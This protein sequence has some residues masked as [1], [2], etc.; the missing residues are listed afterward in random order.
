VALRAV[1]SLLVVPLVVVPLAA[2]LLAGCGF[3]GASNVSHT[4][5][6][7]FVLRGRVTVPVAGSGPVAD[8]TA[9]TSALP[10]VAAGTTVLVSDPDGHALAH[11]ELGGGVTTTAT[12]GSSAAGCDFPFQV[13]GVPGG[14]SRYAVSVAGRPPQTFDAAALREDQL[15][16]LVLTS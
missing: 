13:R 16:V 14:V 8:G 15:A 6:S 12:P 1:R 4:K 3:V 7:G 11:G 10:G 5:P 9:C 2:A